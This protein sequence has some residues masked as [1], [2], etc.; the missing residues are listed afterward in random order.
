[1]APQKAELFFTWQKKD[2]KEKL[3]SALPPLNRKILEKASSSRAK[4]LSEVQAEIERIFELSR[5]VAEGR[6][7]RPMN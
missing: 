1:M 2:L 6:D 7:L 5:W 4:D 3:K